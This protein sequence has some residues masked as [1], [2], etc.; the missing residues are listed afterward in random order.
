M[1]E[2]S[3]QMNVRVSVCM[4]GKEEQIGRLTDKQLINHTDCM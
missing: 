3:N 1:L 2:T 4:A